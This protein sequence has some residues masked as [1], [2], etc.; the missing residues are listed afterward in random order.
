MKIKKKKIFKGEVSSNVLT[1]IDTRQLGIESLAEKVKELEKDKKQLEKQTKYF[2]EAL[3]KINRRRGNDPD[4]DKKLKKLENEN[5]KILEQM[6]LANW[7]I[8][9]I[10]DGY[11]E[12]DDSRAAPVKTV[13]IKNSNETPPETIKPH[14]SLE[15]KKEGASD[16]EEGLN[17][18]PSYH[19]RK[20]DIT[21]PSQNGVKDKVGAPSVTNGQVGGGIVI[22]TSKSKSLG[23][24]EDDLIKVDPIIIPSNS[25]MRGVLLNGLDAPTG[26]NSRND[27]FPV[28]VRIQ[29]DAILPNHYSADVKECFATLSGYGDLST[30][31]AFLRGE[32]ISCVTKSGNVIEKKFSAYVVGEGG[33]AGLR[34]RLV[35]RTGSLLAKVALAGFGQAV[36]EAFGG[37]QVPVINTSGTDYYRDNLNSDSMAYAAGQG[38]SMA[39]ERL[40]DYY[41]EL[42][43]Q[44]FPIIEIDTLRQVDIIVLSKIEF[45]SEDLT[46]KIKKD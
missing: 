36:A 3:E 35:T 26:N 39:M 22:Y 2:A 29:D 21:T 5:R 19:F 33:K 32:K 17:P 38:A 10:K 46:P 20:A 27:P 45:T 43:D 37:S 12:S 11:F 16:V 1:D 42:A 7:D 6:K 23:P 44:I 28:L 8:K 13:I 15:S 24:S 9:D 30:E 40:A 31:R 41:M 14:V 18:D 34:G 25:I 4:M